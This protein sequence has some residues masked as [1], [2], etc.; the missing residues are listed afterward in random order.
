[1]FRAAAS[2]PSMATLVILTALSTLALNMFLPSLSAMAV[3]F[4]VDYALVALAIAGYLGIT[5]LLMLVMGP[6]SDRFGRRPVLL[7]GLAVFTA[8]SLVC[9]LTED[10]W[11]FLAFRVCQ[12]TV[13]AGWALSLAAIRDIVP[14]QEAASK[15]GYVTMAMAVGPMTGPL[16]GGALEELFGWRANF[17]AFTAFGA[18]A[19]CLTWLDLG[20]TN[21]SRSATF[22]AQ[23]RAYPELFL[24]R[25][26]WGFALCMAFSVGAF[27]TFLTGAP[28]VAVSLLGLSPAELGFYLG[29]ITAGFAFGSF[30]SGRF[31]KRHALTS[32][33]IAGRLVATAGLLLGFGLFLAGQVHVL[34]LFGA[35]IFVGLG[36]GLT[37]PSS[38]AGALSVRPKLAGSA[39]GLAG[40]LA[41]G[42]GALL[43]SLTGT[44][45]NEATGVY[46]LLGMMLACVALSLLAA[47]SVLWIDRREG[48][49]RAV[50]LT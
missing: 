45:V 38:N 3:D 43:T 20:E 46:G 23:F 36:N 18:A 5:A 24:S 6:L 1:M 35:T 28:L 26:F 29:T 9:A 37:M 33:M 41:V 47:L 31:A 17:W 10:I 48:A 16:L 32:M 11:I 13:I 42:L 4:E 2:P 15:I 49:V 40:A 8:A 22:G 34:S 27:Y 21:R 30:L 44:V 14:E 39:A 7:V 19:F 25:R 50:E 12:G